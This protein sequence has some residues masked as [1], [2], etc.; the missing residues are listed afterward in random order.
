MTRDRFESSDVTMPVVDGTA[1]V[2]VIDEKYP[3]LPV[4]LTSGLSAVAPDA[5]D[6]TGL[7]EFIA[8]PYTASGLRG[9]IASI[10]RL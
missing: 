10:L 5:A 7:R 9:A 3:G 2:H 1:I 8:K 4:L 6:H